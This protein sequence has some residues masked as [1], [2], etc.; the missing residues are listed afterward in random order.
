MDPTECNLDEQGQPHCSVC[1][2][3]AIAS[4]RHLSH[5][6]FTTGAPVAIDRVWGHCER[7]KAGGWWKAERGPARRR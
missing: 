5:F 4:S 6:D 7:C 3:K 2:G 1:G